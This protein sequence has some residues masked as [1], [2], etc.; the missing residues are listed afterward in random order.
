MKSMPERPQ[1]GRRI[2]AVE[3]EYFL[4]DEL[5]RELKAAGAA[6]LGPV[7]SVAA[8]LEALASD[9]TP[10]AA[11]L[12]VNLGGENG[13][14][15]GG[16]ASREERA[17]S[18]HDRVRPGNVART[19]WRGASIGKAGRDAR[20]PQGAWTPAR[21]RQ[22]IAADDGRS[23]EA[24]HGLGKSARRANQSANPRY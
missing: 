7:S 1:S 8:A 15:R 2:L 21:D 10:D 19:V 14:S 11:V 6:V 9:R 24:W 12:G 17:V 13:A 5:D 16:C 18:V 3:D 22:L 20:D 4:A 23:L